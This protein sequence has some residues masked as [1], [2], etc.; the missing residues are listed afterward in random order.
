[1]S[2]TDSGSPDTSSSGTSCTEVLENLQRYLDG[3]LP[4]SR[5]SQLRTHLAEC[6][7]CADRAS[8]EEQIRAVLREC[9]V[10]QAPD[11]LVV[12]I[13]RHLELDVPGAGNR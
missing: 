8:F 10:E 4:E 13:R 5:L 6:Y 1:M 11:E 3:E 12:R 7:P 2:S 9:C